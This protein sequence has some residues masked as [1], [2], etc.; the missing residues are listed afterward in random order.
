MRK[1]ITILL[2]AATSLL[3]VTPVLAGEIKIYELK[4]YE[5]LIEKTLKFNEAPMLRVKVAAGKLPPV[6][7]RLPEEPLVAKP[8]EEIGQYGGVWRQAHMGT[9]DRWQNSYWLREPLIRWNKDYTDFVPNV[10]KD[11]KFS[12]DGKSITFFL[13]K[14]IKWSDGFPFTADD[15][16]F[17]WNEIILNDELTPVKPAS[18]KVGGELG[19]LEKL[20]DYTIRF[21]FTGPY[22]TILEELVWYNC[23]AP[24]HYLKLFHPKYTSMDKIKKI[25]KKEG[26]DLWIDLFGSKSDWLNNPGCPQIDAWIPQNTQD[27]PIQIF[28]R[29]PYY[30]KI[31]TEGNQLPYIDYIRR[32]LVGDIETIV[33]KAIAGEV[34]LQSRRIRGLSN[35]PLVMENQEKGDYR[36]IQCISLGK[37]YATIYFNFHHK[38]SVLRKLF[39]DKRFR[40]ALSIAINREEISS[41]LYMGLA[42]PS[43]AICAKGSP[44]Y[45]EKFAKIYTEYDPERANKILDEI[46]LKWDKNHEY[47][48]RPDDKRLSFVNL[49]NT[50]WPAENVEIQ[51]LIKGYWKKIGIQVAVK[52]ADRALYD[53]RVSA[54]E[55]DIASYQAR[56]GSCGFSPLKSEYVFPKHAHIG[57]APMWGLWFA[58]NGKA[59]E[60]PPEKVKYLMEI[61]NKALSEPSPERKI[62]L[63][64]EAIKIFAENLWIIGVVQEAPQAEFCIVKNNFRNVPE[65]LPYGVTP[66]CHTAQ[67]FIKK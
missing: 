41:L 35:Y 52:P 40:I 5:Q 11:W 60:E 59:G 2:I 19:T 28:E 9:R 24:K 4:A 54:A 32:T 64:K 61:Y 3:G 43:Q 18:F 25:M 66:W 34:D 21:S 6:E 37:N 31:D 12:E 23:G 56:M 8:I 47:R 50:S 10:A 39:R 55:H 38:D 48:L 46:G 36:V 45:E 22:P 57:W 51:E 1:L 17:W 30:W 13:R 53:T 20:D 27:K 62:S 63:L 65:P 44:W 33:L 49:V 14:G 16:M 29:N 7:E 58:S 67:F 26:F 42:V 15:F